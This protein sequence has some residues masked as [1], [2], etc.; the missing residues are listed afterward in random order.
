MHLC[1]ISPQDVPRIIDLLKGA[2]KRVT[3]GPNVSDGGLVYLQDQ[4]YEFQTREGGRKWSIYG[5]PVCSFS[6]NTPTS[7]MLT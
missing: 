1:L 2:V 5:S 4:T 6:I 7:K 3:D